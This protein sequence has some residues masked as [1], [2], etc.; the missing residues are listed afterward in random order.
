VRRGWPPAAGLLRCRAEG[1][2]TRRPTS[3]V[4]TVRLRDSNVKRAGGTPALRKPEARPTRLA[5]MS[6]VPFAGSGQGAATLRRETRKD[7]P[8]PEHQQNQKSRR[9]AG[10]TKTGGATHEASEYVASALRGLRARSSDPTKR[11]AEGFAAAGASTKSKEPARRRRYENRR[12]DPQYCRR[13]GTRDAMLIQCD[14]EGLA[15]RR[16]RTG[17]SCT[18][19][20]Q[21]STWL[22]FLKLARSVLALGGFAESNFH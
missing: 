10:A 1:L 12:R 6:R 9:D 18:I 16:L 8:L 11:N 15:T 20:L 13:R 7:S 5:N 17:W 21:T 14:A 4:K 2:A 3:L 19:L 22:D